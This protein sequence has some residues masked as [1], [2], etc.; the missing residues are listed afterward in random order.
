MEDYTDQSVLITPDATLSGLDSIRAAFTEFFGGL[1][2]PGTYEFTMDR[3]VISGDVAH[4][5]WHSDNEGVNIL[6]GADTFLVR[7][8]KIAV[9]TFAGY[10]Q[11]NR[12]AP[13]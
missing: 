9:Q 4:I 5:V 1:F 13:T 2:K 8:G 10:I 11:E 12:F 3:T 7:D 6:F